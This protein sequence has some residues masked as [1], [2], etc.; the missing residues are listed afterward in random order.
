M[1]QNIAFGDS[2]SQSDG[3]VFTNS[4]LGHAIENDIFNIPRLSPFSNSE[5]CLPFV[6]VSDDAFGL[7]EDM[8]KPYPFQ[9][10]TFE[11]KVFDY[12]FSR[13]RR[14]IE[15]SF[16][17]ATAR[18]RIFRRTI[19]AKVSTVRSV[20]KAIV[21]LHNF[22]LEKIHKG[23]NQYI[24]YRQRGKLS[25]SSWGLATGTKDV[26]RIGSNNYSKTAKVIGDK[27]KDYFVNYVQ[28]IGNGTLQTKQ[29]EY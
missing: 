3:S 13:A 29:I 21:R 28:W 25:C 11:E 7:K 26:R 9:N 10:R 2:G 16:G 4:F 22:L 17:I 5:T 23:D 8:M 27:F 18:F 1:I 12:R 20:R 19:N 14:I 6:F 15:N 24:L